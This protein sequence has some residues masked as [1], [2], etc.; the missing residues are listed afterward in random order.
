[1]AAFAALSVAVTEN[2]VA[3]CAIAAP[4]VCDALLY[5]YVTPPCVQLDAHAGIAT[6]VAPEVRFETFAVTVAR[7]PASVAF[8]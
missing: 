3:P 8:A 6:A 7:P 2:A 1:M 5:A 4:A